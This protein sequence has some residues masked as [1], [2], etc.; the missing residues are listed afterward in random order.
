MCILIWVG[1]KYLSVSVYIYIYDTRE[2][3]RERERERDVNVIIYIYICKHLYIDI[4][5]TCN[6]KKDHLNIFLH[7]NL[8]HVSTYYTMCFR[9]VWV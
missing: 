3:E 5:N 6:M 7:M 8:H 1:L 4:D 9:Y 2:R